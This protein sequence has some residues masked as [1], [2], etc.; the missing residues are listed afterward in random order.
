MRRPTRRL[1]PV[2]ALLALVS[3]ELVGTPDPAGAQAPRRYVD[4]VFSGVTVTPDLVYGAAPD[5]HREVQSLHLD[6]YE[7]TGDVELQRPTVILAHGGGFTSGDRQ[8]MASVA[9]GFAR[10][11]YVAA[12]IEYRMDE[13]AG[14]ID[15]P[16]SDAERARILDAVHDM[17]AAV[18][19]VRA[20]AAE[21]RLHPDKV[22]VGGYSAGGVMAVVAA[23]TPDEPGDSGNPGHPSGVCTALARAG[24]G[25]PAYV[26]AG[27]AGALF[28]H[29]DD[30]TVVPYLQAL[31]THQAML[32]AGL[33]SRMVA[34]PGAGHSPPW[35]WGEVTSWLLDTMVERT[36]PCAAADPA[37]AAFVRAA[38]ADLL[39]RA[40]TGAELDDEVARLAAGSGRGALLDRLTRSDEWIGAIVEDLYRTTLGRGS[41]PAGLAHWVGEIRSGRRSV[42]QVAARFY[43]AHEYYVG[44]GGGSATTWITA[45]YDA[46]LHRSPDPAGLAHWVGQTARR[47]REHVAGRLYG[48]LESRRDRVRALY[49]HLLGRAPDDAGLAY[50]A[51]RVAR[52]GDLALARSLAASA[53]YARRALLRYPEP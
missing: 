7:P 9:R 49:D 47:G 34:Y 15:F 8:N 37:H 6:L 23:T 2:L 22:T 40:P 42:A 13:G 17:Q 36:T 52:D 4:E 50:W 32:D 16:P 20:H 45:L 1:A 43:A 3:A 33:P 14:S 48:S 11:G 38:Y 27:D 31:L 51:G 10:R 41:D 24:A 25:D 35:D 30:D 21:H 19:W 26:D 28:L 39:G 53:E 12:S 29:G 5:E 44:R 46:I 18:R